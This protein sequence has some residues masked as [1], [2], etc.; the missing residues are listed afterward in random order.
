MTGPPPGERARTDAPP[1]PLHERLIALSREAH[2]RG[3]HEA[4]YHA[5]AAAMHAADDA[6]DRRA[7]AE[8]GRE[9]EAQIAWIDQHEPAHRLSTR[10][11]GGR[12]HPGVYAMLVRQT[13][14]HVQMHAHL[15]A[16]LHTQL[17]APR[18]PQAPR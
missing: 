8:V 18:A 9:A 6:A 10:A 17:H 16:P 3:H 7:L 4:A 5:L 11:A 2:A 13:A 14:A 12:N 1:P 15:P